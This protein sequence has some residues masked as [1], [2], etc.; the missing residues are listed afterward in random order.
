ME[1][2][3]KFKSIIEFEAYYKKGTKDHPAGSSDI[4]EESACKE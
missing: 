1:M 4:M 2:I 3:L